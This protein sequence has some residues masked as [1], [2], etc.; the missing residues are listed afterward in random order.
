VTSLNEKGYSNAQVSVPKSL[1][2]PVQKPSKPVDT[3]LVTSG[4]NSLNIFYKHPESHGGDVITK[5]KVLKPSPVDR[6]AAKT[7]HL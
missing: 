6:K 5:Y 2:P 1:A 4:A 7:P 3:Y